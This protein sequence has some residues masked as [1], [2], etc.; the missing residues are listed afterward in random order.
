MTDVNKIN[1]ITYDE[2]NR[3]YTNII[4]GYIL[5]GYTVNIPTM[6][7]MQNEITKTDLVALDK[8]FVRIIVTKE[9][10]NKVGICADV[11]RITELIYNDKKIYTGRNTVWNDNADEVNILK[12][13]YCI[14]PAAKY[15]EDS[16]KARF[17]I[18]EE[19]ANTV[20]AIQRIRRQR[21]NEYNND[22]VRTINVSVENKAKLIG[23]INT[24]WGYKR[25]TINDIEDVYK[26]TDTRGRIS[27]VIKI[28][29]KNV[30]VIGK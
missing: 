25:I 13:Y 30:I 10:T 29:N 11:V 2:I 14:N 20:R 8:S 22:E 19:E 3:R 26:T 5:R 9:C 27:Y 15:Y 28:K 7:G 18:T 1:T 24:R 16:A 4:T 6:R 17:V 12:E 23:R 21:K